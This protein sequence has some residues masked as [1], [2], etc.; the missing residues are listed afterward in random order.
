MFFE[1]LSHKLPT[2]IRVHRKYSSEAKCGNTMSA[3]DSFACFFVIYIHVFNC[4]V[5]TTNFENRKEIAIIGGYQHPPNV[6][7]VKYLVKKIDSQKWHHII[8]H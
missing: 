8:D 5:N 7:A 1:H 6:D 4:R 2:L 3:R